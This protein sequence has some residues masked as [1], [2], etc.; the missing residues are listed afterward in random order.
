MT[1]YIKNPNPTPNIGDY[2]DGGYYTGMVW[3]ELVQSSTLTDINVGIK[4]FTVPDMNSPMMY[5]DQLLELRSRSNPYNKMISEVINVTDNILTVNVGKTFGS[6]TL[7]DW[8]I[9]ARYRL[10]VAP[11]QHGE[12]CDI[13]LKNTNS[14]FPIGCQTLNDG[15]F[16]TNAMIHAGDEKTYPAAW[17]ARGLNINGYDDWYIPARDEL[18]LCWRN[19]KPTTNRNYIPDQRNTTKSLNYSINGAY[20][21]VTCANGENHNASKIRHAYQRNVPAMTT[22]PLF[23]SNGAESLTYDRGHFWTS[24][25]FNSQNAWTQVWSILYPGKQTIR[26]KKSNNFVR[27][28]RRSII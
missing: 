24:T 23:K 3:V 7:N 1:T 11:K 16:S 9:M 5:Q 14:P 2:L 18:E 6:G 15:W 8:S 25:E 21:D 22:V 28:V 27:A 20:N 4:S 13:A 26:D 12:H 10:I 17:W 19:L